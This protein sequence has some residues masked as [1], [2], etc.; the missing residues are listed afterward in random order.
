MSS[1][2]PLNRLGAICLGPGLGCTLDLRFLCLRGRA[3]ALGDAGVMKSAHL[4]VELHSN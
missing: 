2:T 3:Q 1:R 4:I